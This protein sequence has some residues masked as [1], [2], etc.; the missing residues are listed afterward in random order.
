MESGYI[1]TGFADQNGDEV[2]RVDVEGNIFILG[3]PLHVVKKLIEQHTLLKGPKTSFPFVKTSEEISGEPSFTRE[4]CMT[5]LQQINMV[6]GLTRADELR[7]A[8][9]AANKA[10]AEMRSRK[11]DEFVSGPDCQPHRSKPNEE[12]TAE[13][14]LRTEPFTD[15]E[16]FAIAALKEFGTLCRENNAQYSAYAS[17]FI[18]D[19]RVQNRMHLEPRHTFKFAKK[20]LDAYGWGMADHQAARLEALGMA[21]DGFTDLTYD[22]A[23]DRALAKLKEQRIKRGELPRLG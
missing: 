13:D 14:T 9:E 10:Y 23:F 6:A 12:T 18:E 20:Q 5:W 3:E 8:Y 15:K 21:I 7:F 1:E 2:L 17:E 22:Q 4:L 11:M 19:M 16:R